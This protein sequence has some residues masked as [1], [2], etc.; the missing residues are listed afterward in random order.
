M[1]IPEEVIKIHGITNEKVKDAPTFEALAE[2]IVAFIG[3]ADLAGYN[4]NK[5]D[6]PLLAEEFLRVGHDIDLE[7]KK[8]VDVQNIFHKMEQRTLV[9]AYQFYC[10]KELINAHEAM[11]DVDATW[12]VLKSQLDKYTDLKKDI[13]FLSE[14]SKAGNFTLVDFAG[15][16]GL[17]ENNE[18]VYNF[19]K[20]KGKKVSEVFKSDYGYYDW[21]MQGDFPLQTKKVLTQLKLNTLKN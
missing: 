7:T 12:E 4:S 11:S 5:F 21:M 19:G 1:E 16:L 9:A 15:R 6:I 2:R 8:F 14:F 20:H 18:C 17:N 13:G 10:Q 3:E